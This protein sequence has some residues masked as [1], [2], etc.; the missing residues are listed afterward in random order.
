MPSIVSEH[1]KGGGLGR[2]VIP[3][4][5]MKLRTGQETSH[6]FESYVITTFSVRSKHSEEPLLLHA[7]LKP[8]ISVWRFFVSEARSLSREA[9]DACRGYRRDTWGA[10]H[11][12]IQTVDDFQAKFPSLRESY[13]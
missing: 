6:P 1:H 13:P 8:W 7:L 5:L 9:Q 2:G 3:G 10:Q 11:A 4:L 12:P